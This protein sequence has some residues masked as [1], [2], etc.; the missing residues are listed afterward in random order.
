MYF[1]PCLLSNIPD[2]R[3]TSETRPCSLKKKLKPFNL[4]A[5]LFLFFFVSVQAPPHS[6]SHSRL[7]LLHLLKRQ[8]S[9]FR[10][11]IAV[12]VRPE[13]RKKRAVFLANWSTLSG[14]QTP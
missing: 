10:A 2:L 14:P 12:V 5:D 3:P 13:L 8:L 9:S 4:C 7:A 11:L 1:D 6:R